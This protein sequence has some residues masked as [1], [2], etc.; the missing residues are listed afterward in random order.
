M[1]A[2]LDSERGRD[3][4][5]ERRALRRERWRLLAQIMRYAEIPLFVLSALWL[6]LLVVEFT[7]G[8]GP[9]L[10]GASYVIWAIFGLQ[11]LLE[12]LIA[13]S[14]TVFLRKQWLTLLALVVPAF[15]LF[16]IARVAR[17]LR[18]ARA[19][20][21]LRLLRVVTTA[22]RGMRA[23]AQSMG[24]RGAGYV[25]AITVVVLLAGAAGMLAFER[26]EA[27]SP[28]AS[29]GT[30]LWWTAMVLTTMGSDYW[31]LSPEGRLLCLGLS[32]YAFGAFGYLTAALASFFV[33]R[34][35]RDAERESSAATRASIDARLARIESLL[36]H[37]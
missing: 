36:D 7:R 22:N 28:I 19:A 10:T 6:V 2:S 23:L 17:L 27:G 13:P 25:A 18:G 1:T 24:R 34:E 15:R 30:A 9:V 16:R 4:E 12:L 14:R 32:L 11:F 8:L 29:Y 37:K 33:D 21:G 26:D 35:Q 31:P 5:P 3:R 20:R